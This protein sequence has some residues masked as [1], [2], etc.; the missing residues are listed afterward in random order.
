[1]GHNITSTTKNIKFVFTKMFIITM[2]NNVSP[3]P[4]RNIEIESQIKNKESLEHLPKGQ[5]IY[6]TWGNI[7]FICIKIG[8]LLC[9]LNIDY[10][11]PIK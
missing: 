3:I 4:Y 5:R 9:N 7:F 11:R 8:N 1:M 6:N 10:L 2:N